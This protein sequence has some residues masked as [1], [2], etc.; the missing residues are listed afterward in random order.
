[1]PTAQAR[2]PVAQ[3]KPKGRIGVIVRRVRPFDN[4]F[5]WAAIFLGGDLRAAI[6]GRRFPADWMFMH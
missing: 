3:S 1:M 4:R 2:A 5:F 6:F